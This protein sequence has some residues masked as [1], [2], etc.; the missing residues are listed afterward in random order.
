MQL[1]VEVFRELGEVDG[2]I[3]GQR[4][5][6]RLNLKQNSTFLIDCEV[7]SNVSICSFRPEVEHELVA[8]HSE[9]RIKILGEQRW[10][11]RLHV[12]KSPVHACI[13][14]A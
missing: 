10:R 13:E 3:H 14:Q 9:A 12:V 11:R 1:K 7:T 5:E 2:I 6:K 8:R 4:A